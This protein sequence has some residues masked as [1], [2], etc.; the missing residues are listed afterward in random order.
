MSRYSKRIS[1]KIEKQ[2]KSAKPAPE[3]PGKDIL[4]IILIVINFIFL[5]A[6]WPAL[7]LIDKS[8]YIAIEITL[9]SRYALRHAELHEKVATYVKYLSYVCLVLAFIL[10]IISLYMHY[11]A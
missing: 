1:E 2:K 8:V 9:L 4:L 3:K 5:I 6:S 10:F 7:P 11:I